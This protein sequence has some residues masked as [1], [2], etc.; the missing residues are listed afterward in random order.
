MIINL[1]KG[2]S[3]RIDLR[4]SSESFQYFSPSRLENT[5]SF[6]KRCN[7]NPLTLYAAIP[8]GAKTATIHPLGLSK[9]WNLKFKSLTTVSIRKLLPVPNIS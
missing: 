7:V 9:S 1:S 3:E 4:L 8:V 6:I 2:T 5:G